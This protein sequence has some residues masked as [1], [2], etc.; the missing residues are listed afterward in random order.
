MLK[1]LKNKNTL[2]VVRFYLL[3]FL[4]FNSFKNL[5]NTIGL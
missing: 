3:N 4:S 5:Y 1:Y 2:L